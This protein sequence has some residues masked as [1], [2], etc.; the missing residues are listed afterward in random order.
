MRSPR[1]PD[2]YDSLQYLLSR[3]A[4]E[5]LESKV[6]VDDSIRK[7]V[8]YVGVKRGGRFMARGTGF[9]TVYFVGDGLPGDRG[10]Q[11]I[12]TARHVLDGIDDTEI[13]IRLN[14]HDGAARV[15]A[16]EASYWKPHPSGHVDLVTCPTGI[17][18]D[19]F[20]IMHLDVDSGMMFTDF[21][22]PRATFGIGDEV[23]IAGMFQ[24]HMGEARNIPIIR[25]GSIAAMPEEP[26]ETNY[27]SH[28]AYLIEARS[29]D[30]L[31][32][33]PVFAASSYAKL[34]DGKVTPRAQI[35]FK[36]LGVLLGT[37]EVL[38][39]K[40]YVE[41]RSSGYE[42]DRDAIRT[43]MNTG[44]GIVAPVDLLVETVKHPEIVKERADFTA[45]KDP[46]R[47][48][49]PTSVG[50]EPPTTEDNPD[51]REDFNSLLDA[52]VAGKPRGQ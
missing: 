28:H 14:T 6:R 32:G 18:K 44:I 42:S 4:F 52:A 39:D 46:N 12:V 31:S 19:D 27:G 16:T 2:S 21:A 45:M 20:D 43:L 30:G 5:V 38:N 41:V 48:Y 40:D 36:L 11:N 7:T 22:N 34:Q 1:K 3:Y 8:V 35:N 24:Q 17:P 50:K 25:T 26:I 37:N 29:I 23:V 33:S 15:I 10:Y 13:F 51:H 49:R 9:I 47:R